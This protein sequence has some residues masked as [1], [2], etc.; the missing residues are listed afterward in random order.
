M[1]M[2]YHFSEDC[3]AVESLV[4]S[5]AATTTSESLR[6]ASNESALCVTNNAACVLPNAV[7]C[8]T[9]VREQTIMQPN[10]KH[11]MQEFLIHQY[12]QVQWG[13]TDSLAAVTPGHIQQKMTT[14]NYDKKV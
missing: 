1:I 9:N 12:V 14:R 7:L 4:E 10:A 3:C 8:T 5:L 6:E 2:L 11:A 13:M